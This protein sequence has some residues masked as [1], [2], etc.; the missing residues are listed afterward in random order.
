MNSQIASVTVVAATWL[1]TLM[2]SAVVAQELSLK[3]SLP[4]DVP[5][6][7]ESVGDAHPSSQ[8]PT[9]SAVAEADRLLSSAQQ[10]T[11]LGELARARGLLDQAVVLDPTSARLAYHRARLLEQIGEVTAG[12]EEYC[13]YLALAPESAEKEEIGRHVAEIAP[14]RPPFPAAATTAF[15]TG[16]AHYDAGE[17]TLAATAFA[18]AIAEA[19]EWSSPYFNRAL[20][21]LAGDSALTMPAGANA[22]ARPAGDSASAAVSYLSRYLDL[23]P[24][25]ED[26]VEVERLRELLL[27]PPPVVMVRPYSP[28]LSV[29]GGIL[30]PGLG[31]FYTRRPA[32]GLLA[33]TAVGGATYLALRRGS[34]APA[35]IDGSPTPAPSDP[36][37]ER[38][39]LVAGLSA[40][41]A[42]TLLS[43]LEAALYAAK[44]E[45][46][47]EP[48]GIG[49]GGIAT[50]LTLTPPTLRATP[51]GLR[52][53]IGLQL[54]IR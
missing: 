29:V 15:T 36:T 14:L 39:Y 28:A 52:A 47:K 23:E 43:A 33:L 18:T 41:A 1:V 8:L 38:P 34:T 3:R 19:P 40:A 45:E 11:L 6:L 27:T 21:L 53:D 51:G 16:I 12:F 17:F 25:A 46:V 32:P 26:R 20:A 37:S 50:E 48:S 13:R 54:R 30:V 9:P 4:A 49:L 42:V 10:A 7:C 35:A 5:V 2:P 22:S 44:V 24:T 31:Q